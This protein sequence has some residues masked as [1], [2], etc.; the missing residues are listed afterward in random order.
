MAVEFCSRLLDDLPD[1][2][3]VS[4]LKGNIQLWNRRA[5]VLFKISKVDA[6]GQN[7]DIVIPEYLRNAHWAG[8]HRA[9]S[10]D[11][12]RFHGASVRTKALLGDGTFALL[13]MAFSLTHDEYGHLVG[14]S[15]IAR[16]SMSAI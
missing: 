8:F 16:P 9:I 6:L 5:E 1:A 11:N 3:I 7:L 4:D 14:V 15:A 10:E 12:T 2:L 13:D